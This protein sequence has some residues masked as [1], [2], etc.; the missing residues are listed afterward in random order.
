[1]TRE[2]EKAVVS[3]VRLYALTWTVEQRVILEVEVVEVP[4]VKVE[5]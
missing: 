5:I 3:L 4:E 1:M 2:R